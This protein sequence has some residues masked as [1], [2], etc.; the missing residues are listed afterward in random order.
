MPHFPGVGMCPRYFLAGHRWGP[1][2][3]RVG[4]MLSEARLSS[5]KERGS[6]ELA[7]R[8][9]GIFR[10]IGFTRV[11]GC[12]EQRDFPRSGCSSGCVS[13][14]EGAARSREGIAKTYHPSSKTL[15]ISAL[16][17]TIFTPVSSMTPAVV[18]TAALLAGPCFSN[19]ETMKEELARLRKE[20][21]ELKKEI[22]KIKPTPVKGKWV[23]E[24]SAGAVLTSGNNDSLNITGGVA[25]SR[26]TDV[27]KFR[28]FVNGA[29]GT[30]EG[31]TNSQFVRG[32]AQYNRDFNARYYWYATS[33]LEHD[34][35][36]G[37][38]FRLGVGPGL[39]IHA[40]KT[41]KVEL[42]FEGGLSY[43]YEKFR[44]T[45][46][47]SSLR[48]RGA[49]NFTY[50]FSDTAKF[51]QRF[52]IASDVSDLE[53]FI[54]NAE[55]GVETTLTDKWKLRLSFLDRYVNQPPN[56]L[57]NNDIQLVSSLVWSF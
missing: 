10:R 53:N 43:F 35:V 38:D 33:L 2:S 51:Y 36:G 57:Q 47:E 21:A 31:T 12:G 28:A 44:A 39:G 20:N 54:L 29:Y 27:D 34:K 18:A 24:L 41:E 9:A 52:E 45:D 6:G 14:R 50:K 55:A 22:E 32:G 17:K 13:I 11:P 16:M 3:V 1:A 23:K 5:A 26:E 46:G 42:N 49:Q 48:L 25:V 8:V 15:T 4:C 37:V 7:G 56:G 19:A 30:Q 40:V